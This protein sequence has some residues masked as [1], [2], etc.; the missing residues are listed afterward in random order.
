[1]GDHGINTFVVLSAAGYYS[2]TKR[3]KLPSWIPDWGFKPEVA[4]ISLLEQVG[5]YTT[6]GDSVVDV[7]VSACRQILT[8]AGYTFDKIEHVASKPFVA[9]SQH[10]GGETL[11]QFLG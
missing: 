2:D 8:L 4:I 9:I 5:R 7:S 6:A 3:M 1:M 11:E 10:G